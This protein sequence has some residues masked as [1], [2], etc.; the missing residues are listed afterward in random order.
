MFCLIL[1]VWFG[2]VGF[3]WLM[4]WFGCLLV[5]FCRD[6][7]FGGGVSMVFLVCGL[8]FVVVIV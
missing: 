4:Y 3:V 2:I 1:R 5:V 8:G 7:C 6:C